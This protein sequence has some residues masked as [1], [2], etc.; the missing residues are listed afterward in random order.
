[1]EPEHILQQL[2]K[3]KGIPITSIEFMKYLDEI[4]PLKH[5]RNEFIFPKVS[6]IRP[7]NA[8]GM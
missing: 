4:D 5:L 6:Q 1:M 7:K 3:E 8:P 2:A